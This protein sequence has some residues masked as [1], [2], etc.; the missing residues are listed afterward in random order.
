[1]PAMTSFI[2]YQIPTGCSW[3]E[4]LIVASNNPQYDERL[5]VELR[6]QSKLYIPS[7][8]NIDVIL[9]HT[10]LNVCAVK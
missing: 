1:M 6:V 9:W 8:P 2:C 3:S 10:Q 5:L 4:A 7:T